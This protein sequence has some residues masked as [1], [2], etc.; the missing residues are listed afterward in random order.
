[1]KDNILQLSSKLGIKHTDKTRLLWS[2]THESYNKKDAGGKNNSRSV[3]LGM[4]AFRGLAAR[5]LYQFVPGKGQ[6]LQ[7][8]LGNMFSMGKMQRLFEHWNLASCIRYGDDFDPDKHRHIFVYGVLGYMVEYAN[9]REIRNLII[10]EFMDNRVLPQDTAKKHNSLAQLELLLV[11]RD[12]AKPKI[13]SLTDA[14]LH[15][16]E[17]WSD[18]RLLSSHTSKSPLYARKKAIMGAMADLVRHDDDILQNDPQYQALVSKKAEQVRL[19][20]ITENE[21]K[22]QHFLESQRLKKEAREEKVKSK[23]QEKQEQDKARRIAKAK[24]KMIMEEK[25]KKAKLTDAKPMNAGKRRYLED[26]SK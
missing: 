25:E 17:V 5:L 11:Q 21:R 23:L 20:K 12:M 6:Q 24:R 3:F 14:Q 22:H 2:L 8:T 16:V 19:A 26:K 18:G 4:Y 10:K 15:K 1:M 13:K 7:H 9:E